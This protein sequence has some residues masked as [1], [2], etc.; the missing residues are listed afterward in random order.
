MARNLIKAGHS[1]KV[2]DLNED[3]MQ[4][5][6]QSGAKALPTVPSFVTHILPYSALCK[7][8]AALSNRGGAKNT[9]DSLGRVRCSFQYIKLGF[10]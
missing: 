10:K 5:V 7:Q 8:T 9:V 6:A 1:L 4:Y 2:F 3:A